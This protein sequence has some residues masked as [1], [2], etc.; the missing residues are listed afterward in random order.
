MRGDII[1]WFSLQ[2]EDFIFVV[3]KYYGFFCV[4]SSQLKHLFFQCLKCK[5][6]QTDLRSNKHY[7]ILLLCF[8]SLKYSL[9]Q[10][11]ISTSDVK[12]SSW[13]WEW[14]ECSPGNIY[15][16]GIVDDEHK[17][18][19]NMFA[20]LFSSPLKYSQQEE[21]FSVETGIL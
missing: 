12:R 16:G 18:V 20:Q 11:E 2:S 13:Y 7:K 19:G 14:G 4:L 21:A 17:D 8:P 9:P 6:I 5:Y 3:Q 15:F 10:Y 1:S